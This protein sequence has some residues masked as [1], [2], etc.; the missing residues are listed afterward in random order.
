MNSP[1][2]FVYGTLRSDGSAW[3]VVSPYVEGDPI[4][5]HVHYMRMFVPPH[6]LFPKVVDSADEDDV[7][8]GE[9]LALRNM[10]HVMPM[11]DRYEAVDVGL[12]RRVIVNAHDSDNGIHRAYLYVAADEIVDDYHHVVDGVWKERVR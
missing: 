2:L 6:N 4:D 3:G 10:E 12:Y 5:G 9:I 7:I 8:H 11:L 1:A